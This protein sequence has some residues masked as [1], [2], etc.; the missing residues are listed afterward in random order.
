MFAFWGMY[1]SEVHCTTFMVS[2]LSSFSLCVFSHSAASEYFLAWLVLA[3]T[4][5]MRVIR[6]SLHYG[7]NTSCMCVQDAAGVVLCYGWKFKQRTRRGL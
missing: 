4:G 3:G 7:V 5:A 6:V 1:S 2:R